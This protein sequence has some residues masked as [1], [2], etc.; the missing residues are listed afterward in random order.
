ML[1]LFLSSEPCNKLSNRSA[2]VIP[3][4]LFFLRF[5]ASKQEVTG[6][7]KKGESEGER[8]RG[9]GKIREEG[10]GRGSRGSDTLL[11][12]LSLLSLLSPPL[13]HSQ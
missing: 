10:C 2:E 11:L 8:G 1:L 12:L 13:L 4:T 9:E 3:T 7:G 6:K 5:S